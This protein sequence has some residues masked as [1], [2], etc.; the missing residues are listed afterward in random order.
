MNDSRSSWH[1][2]ERI[3]FSQCTQTAAQGECMFLSTVWRE[4]FAG[5]NFRGLAA[6]KHFEC[7][8]VPRRRRTPPSILTFKASCRH[9]H[10]EDPLPFLTCLSSKGWNRCV[11]MSPP[12]TLG[13]LFLLIHA[14]QIA[15]INYVWPPQNEIASYAYAIHVC[16]LTSTIYINCLVPI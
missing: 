12:N 2:F 11:C 9:A 1:L 3:Q 8:Y 5:Q 7:H 4:I 6:G 10:S 16:T 15:V 13:T 14:A